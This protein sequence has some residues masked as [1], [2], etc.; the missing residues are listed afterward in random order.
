MPRPAQTVTDY[1]YWRIAVNLILKWL[2][3]LVTL[4]FCSALVAA[5]ADGI[6]AATKTI[7]I[8][9]YT[10]VTG[11]V[12]AYHQ[13]TDGLV[14]YFAHL[15]ESGGIKGWKINYTTLDD[16]YQP[17]Q[18][19]VITRR[20][21]ENDKVFAIVGGIGTTTSAAVLPYAQEVGLPVITVGGAPAFYSA[22]NFFTLVPSYVWEAGTLAEFALGG[23]KSKKIGLL[24]QNDELGRTGKLGMETYLQSVGGKLAVQLPIDVKTTD[25]TSHIRRLA[26]AGADTVILFGSNANLASA[27]RTA[28]RM[29]FKTNW[30]APFFVA[31]PATYKLAGPLLDGVYFSSWMLPV[32]SDDSQMAAYR[33]A[34]QKFSPNTPQGVLSLNGWSHATLFRLGFEALLASGQPLTRSNFI[35]AMDSLRDVNPGGARNV[36]FTSGD[37]RGTRQM[38]ILRAQNGGFTLV[39]EFKPFPK[40]VFDK[41]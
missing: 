29:D 2:A 8:G 34:M 10:P 36:T 5:E 7:K 33:A 41:N 4:A 14:A 9:A 28:Q 11:P 22:S 24:W 31:D 19:M 16:G 27:L 35:K 18:S 38:G 17:S 13:I 40:V 37:H 25:F 32:S 15:N 21:V 26:D 1:F 30:L 20:L 3:S 39:R 23:L 12:S 6:D